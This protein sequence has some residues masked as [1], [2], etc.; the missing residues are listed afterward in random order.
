[1]DPTVA[2]FEAGL[3]L[4]K[5]STSLAEKVYTPSLSELNVCD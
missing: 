5:S 1:M 4:P 3:R 2:E